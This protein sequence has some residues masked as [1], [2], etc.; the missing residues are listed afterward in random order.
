[1]R[2]IEFR[3]WNERI[4]EMEPIMTLDWFDDKF[5]VITPKAQI[6]D[7]LI[8]MQFTG[9]L[10]K[11]GKKKVFES[12]FVKNDEGIIAEVVWRTPGFLLKVKDHGVFSFDDFGNFEITGNR[13]ENPEGVT[14]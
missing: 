10:D 11:N 4:K 8:L 1:M 7:Q 12:D 5:D 13:W 3:C 6:R 9:L 14:P 2:P